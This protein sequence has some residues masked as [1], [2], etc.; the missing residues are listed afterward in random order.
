MAVHMETPQEARVSTLVGEI[1]QETQQLIVDQLKLFKVEVKH[2]LNRM[3][4]AVIPVVIGALA[5]FTAIVLFGIGGAELLCWIFPALPLWAGFLIDG[6]VVAI[7][8][9]GLVLAGIHMLRN[10]KPA[11]TALKGLEEN[12]QWKTKN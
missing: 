5:V 1:V 8:G 4:Q 9:V 2:D 10:I 11:E 12:V 7:G 3:M 6:A